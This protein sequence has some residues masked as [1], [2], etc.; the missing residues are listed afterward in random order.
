M[1]KALFLVTELER[2][3]GGL[4]RFT[5]ELLPAWRNAVKHGKAEYEPLVLSV[6]NPALPLGDL[7]PSREF[8]DFPAK[9]IKVYE[10][11]RGGEKCFFLEAK[12][13]QEETWGFQKELWD[14]YRVKSEKASSWDYYGLLNAYWKYAPSLAEFLKREHNHDIRLIDAQDWLAFPAGFLCKERLKVPL[15][16]RYHSGEWGRSMGNP[17]LDAPPVRIEAAALMEADFIQGVSV[18]EAKFELY[19]LL[20]L[21]QEIAKSLENEKS[22]AW[23]EEQSWKDDLYENFLLY[24]AED[25]EI[26]GQNAAGI[27]NGII[28]DEWKKV[29]LVQIY[30]GR[31]VLHG[32]LPKKYYI[33]F[34]G[35]VDK[36]KGIDELMQAFSQVAR[37]HDVGLVVSSNFSQ[38]EYEKYKQ[39]AK[40]LGVDDSIAIYSGWVDE[41]LK[42]SLFCAVDVIALPS[43]YEPFG[44]VTLEGLAADLACE[45][46]HVGGPAVV[47]GATG[48][49]N[50]VIK[51]GVN[52]FKAPMEEDLFELNPNY[53]ARILNMLLKDESLR[54]RISRGGASRV[55]SP[56][57]DWNF[58]VT[59]MQESY[60]K[61]AENYYKWELK[62]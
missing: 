28:L 61:S 26:S 4:H 21:K 19:H 50:E 42:K 27:P 36:R 25:L 46:N 44:L 23:A 53:L 15:H 54:K 58:I 52:G 6:H 59:R 1:K 3:V 51:N 38:G 7:V 47:V 57:F 11:V 9:N 56:W 37:K 62:S 2:P 14:K 8:K 48:G 30:K 31:E 43:L 18:H 12:I 49:M 55:Q 41:K 16:C 13:G 22:S 29:D 20:P 40:D 17:D 45:K 24:E 39:M 32:L 34:I 60:G 5:V 10:A 35:R 33:L